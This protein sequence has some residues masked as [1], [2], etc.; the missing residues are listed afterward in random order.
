MSLT[1]IGEV[2]SGISSIIDKIFPDKTQAEK[3]AMALQLAQ[4]SAE[5]QDKQMQADVDKQEAASQSIF[6]AGWRPFV[7]WVC[8]VGFGVSILGPLLT[9]IATLAGHPIAV[10][11]MDTDL[12][13]TLLFGM[14]GLGGMRTAEK[15]K[16]VSAG[17]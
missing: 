9:W 17:H 2:A 13:V 3:D 14:L 8:G 7:G 4:L 11:A 15:L 1:G 12:L 10:P 16:G 5:Q 6:V